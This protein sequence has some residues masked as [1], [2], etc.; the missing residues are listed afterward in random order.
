M[1]L[2]ILRSKGHILTTS[3]TLSNNYCA[4]NNT[5]SAQGEYFVSRASE[6]LLGPSDAYCTLPRECETWDFH[7]RYIDYL[8]SNIDEANPS[9]V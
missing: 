9:A 5:T 8:F 1:A 3:T 6:F 4:R 7:S 2:P